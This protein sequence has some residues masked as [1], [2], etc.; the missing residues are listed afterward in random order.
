MPL[1]DDGFCRRYGYPSG[2]RGP[3]LRLFCDAYGLN[4]DDCETFLDVVRARQVAG[5]ETVRRGAEG[6]GPT[7]AKVWQ[8]QRGR[9]WLEAI[10]YLDDQRDDWQRHLG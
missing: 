2:P 4:G 1:A 10:D 8:E 3:R 6:G 9:R 7:Y 5:Y